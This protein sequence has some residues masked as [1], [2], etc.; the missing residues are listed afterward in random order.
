MKL[1]MQVKGVNPCSNMGGIILGRN[2]HPVC[3]PPNNINT[4]CARLFKGVRG[5][6]PLREF[7]FKWCNL[8]RFGVYLVQI[9]SLKNFKKYYFLYKDFI[10]YLFLYKNF[11]NY[12]FVYKK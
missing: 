12:Y 9:L 8:V 4:Y 1:S 10:N 3:I 7:F 2:I 5:Y 6:A 11:K